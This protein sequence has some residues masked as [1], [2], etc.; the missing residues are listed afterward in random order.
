MIL[1]NPPMTDLQEYINDG[2]MCLDISNNLSQETNRSD[3]ST[4]DYDNL[5]AICLESVENKKIICLP[6]THRYHPYCIIKWLS[7]Q[8]RNSSATSC[9]ICKQECEYEKLVGDLITTNLT[10]IENIIKNLNCITKYCDRA[11]VQE[12]NIMTLK[13]NYSKVKVILTELQHKEIKDPL[14]SQYIY[15]KIVPLTENLLKLLG[16]AET[17]EIE[18][19]AATSTNCSII[20]ILYKTVVVNKQRAL[21]CL[22]N[23]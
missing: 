19:I 3:N 21:A 15:I 11:Q 1:P 20:T 17:K 12:Y 5:C 2:T 18:R 8:Q 13:R 22:K 10:K 9:P 7:L 23:K 16:E 6:C 4:D 14:N